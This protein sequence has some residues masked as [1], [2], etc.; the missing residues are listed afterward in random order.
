MKP[1]FSAARVALAAVFVGT[2]ALPAT[3]VAQ[4]ERIGTPYDWI[5]RSLRAGLYGGYVS[6]GRG[7]SEIAPGSSA[8]FGARLRARISSPL[9]FELN[10]GLGSSERAVIDP[11]L[12]NGPAAIDTVDVNWLLVEGGFQIALTGARTVHGIQPYVTLGGGILRGIGEEPSELL[13]SPGDEAFRYRVGTAASFA[14]GVGFEWIPAE[15]IGI[16]FELRDHLWR[17]K[18]PDGFFRADVLDRIEELGLPAP[19]ET[20]WTHNLELSAS[21]YYYF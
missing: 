8:V 21:L 13:S 5:D 20:E 1:A 19:R 17:I 11:R 14:G 2:L 3:A 7:E 9:S 18:A 10:V 15:R 12:E 6:T 16:G 4:Q